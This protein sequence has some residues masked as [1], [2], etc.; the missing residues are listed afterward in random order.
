M[1]DDN[2]T[3]TPRD[4][5]LN[6]Y[7]RDKPG[8]ADRSRAEAA[9]EDLRKR[10]GVFVDAVRATRMPMA[11]TDPNL[12]G[13]PIVFANDAFLK[14]TGYSM[15]EVLGQQ[16]HFMNGPTTDPKD[17][18]RFAE[19][20][21]ADQ[22]DIIETV[23]YRKDGSRFVATVLL[24]AFKDEHGHTLNHFMSWLDVTRRVDAEDE[25][26]SLRAAEVLAKVRESERESELGAMTGIHSLA[27]RLLTIPDLSTA[28]SEVLDAAI[29]LF[30]A[31]RGTLQIHDPEDDVLRYAALRG[32]DTS[33][34]HNIPPIDRDFHSTCAVALRT[35]QRVVASDLCADPQWAD[36]APTAKSLGYRAAV[37]TPLKTRREAFQGVMTVHFDRPRIPTEDE[38]R[39]ADLLA[40]LGAHV[41]ERAH[42]EQAL[43]ESEA[44]LRESEERYRSL[45]NT[46]DEGYC[47][48]EV[49]LDEN[50]AAV[51]LIAREANR[52]WQEKTGFSDAIGRRMSE[53]SPNLE[54]HWLDYYESVIRTGQ[55]H[56]EENYMRDVDRWFTAHY[57]LVGELGSNLVAVVFDDITVRKRAEASL[58][59]NAARQSFLLKLSDALRPLAGPADIQAEA[60]RLL[61]E[62][63]NAGWCYYVD[64]DLDRKTGVVLRDSLREGLSS[65]AGVH[66]VSDAPEFLDFLAGGAS[67]TVRD[68]AGY[69]QLPASM[70]Q[71]FTA[72]GFRSFIA[73]PLVKEGRLIASLLV[74]DSEVR[75]WSA[76]EASLL[77][78]VAERT[79][80]AVERAHA[81]DALRAS[82][83]HAKTLLAELQHRVRNTLGVVRSIAK[84][85]AENSKNV[86]DM[87]DH[88]QGRLDAFSRVQAA[89]T[90]NAEGTV[91]LASIIEDELLA[92]AVHGGKQVRIVGPD[93]WLKPKSAERLSLAVHELTTNA[94]KHGALINGDG[95]VR[96]RWA[97]KRNGAGEE[98]V[99]KWLESG[100]QIDG[101][102]PA[103]EGFGMEL[104]LRLLPYDVGGTTSVDFTPTGL[105]FEFR[106]PLDQ[107]AA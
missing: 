69:E 76:S 43:R 37:S 2:S 90:R 42:S 35:E 100:V 103:R 57:S 99:F 22:D 59:E 11:L 85:T 62:R 73:A 102:K 89:L 29:A 106:M 46:M 92:H 101:R 28:L 33:A 9:I 56:R 78:D 86:D 27:D 74:A 107:Q 4:R 41:I 54:K 40:R 63:L 65:L 7:E 16:P 53:L 55:P 68:Y 30:H 82:E 94:V 60:T 50:G 24:S 23:Q 32:F 44:A 18:A 79:W 20:I 81:E 75:D 15:N 6:A 13:N 49:V 45:F 51:D 26:A 91:R 12:P 95:L 97:R 5:S 77:V 8:T 61:R 87:L 19:A 70:R 96:I 105:A 80:A 38:L 10:G 48:V 71:N 14:L 34:L 93:I 31:D 1:K 3:P 83:R 17:A 98:L 25:I 58:R 88:F 72:L 52:A 21:R 36:H 39:W 67:L 47:I 104:L 64:W 84:R 66:D